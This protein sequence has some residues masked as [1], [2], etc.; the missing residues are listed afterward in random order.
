MIFLSAG[1]DAHK[2]DLFKFFKLTDRAY[3]VM[4]ELV[5]DV[6]DRCCAGRLVSVLEG[7]YHVPTLVRCC[8]VHARALATHGQPLP[9]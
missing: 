2:D 3:K 4:T 8:T 7:G 1:F 6:A 5:M 9:V